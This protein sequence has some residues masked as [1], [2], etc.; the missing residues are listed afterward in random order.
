MA[1]LFEMMY[2]AFDLENI[3]VDEVIDIVFTCV[4][5]ERIRELEK[6]ERK[7]ESCRMCE[8]GFQATEQRQYSECEERWMIYADKA[9]CGI[10]QDVMWCIIQETCRVFSL[11]KPS[12]KQEMYFYSL[13]D[14]SW[15]LWARIFSQL[16][17][18][19][20]IERLSDFVACICKLKFRR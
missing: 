20:R 16:E 15:M 6:L 19:E 14:M 12:E 7:N 18:S 10:P 4:L 8:N 17:N 1:H 2:G 11:P 9:I 13:F 5:E 3:T